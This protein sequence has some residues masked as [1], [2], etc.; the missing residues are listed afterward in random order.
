MH[1]RRRKSDKVRRRQP[2]SEAATHKRLLVFLLGLLAASA[3]SVQAQRNLD[4]CRVTTSIWS[5]E[6]KRGTGIYEVGKF[7]VD[8]FEDGARKTFRYESEDKAFLIE[9]EVQYGDFQAVE[10]GKPTM[11]NLSLLVNDANLPGK[12][13][14]LPPSKRAQLTVTNGERYS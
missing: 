4:V 1:E 6:E 12:E 11:I 3:V 13:S 10:K 5:I 7:P 2:L 9:A 8:D 14:G